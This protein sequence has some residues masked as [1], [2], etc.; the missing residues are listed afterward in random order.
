MRF[1]SGIEREV[2][3]DVVVAGDDELKF[4]GVGAQEGDG[5]GVLGIETCGGEVAGVDEDV[6]RWEGVMDGKILA[7]EVGLGGVQEVR[8]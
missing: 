6:C 7:G 3:G 5:E 8:V 2:E 1:S 4:C